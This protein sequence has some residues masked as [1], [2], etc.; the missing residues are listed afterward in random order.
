[1]ERIRNFL[2]LIPLFFLL[3]GCVEKETVDDI[4]LING[5]GFDYAE[6]G[7][8]IGTILFP[9]FMKDQP[10]ENKILTAEAAIKKSV[11]Q[12]IQK[13]SADPIVTGKMRVVLFGEELSTKQGILELVDAFQ[14]DPGVGSGIY[15]ATVDG[16]AEEILKGKYGIKGN[17][18]HIANLLDQNVKRED[19]PKTNLQRFLADFYQKGKTPYIPQIK[20]ISD[21]N[22]ELSGVGLFK[23]GKIIDTI[24]QDKMF[25]FKLLVDKF[26]EGMHRVGIEKG[27]AAIRS[28]RSSHNFELTGRNPFEVTVKIRV[29]GVINEFT[30]NELT[31]KITKQ[32]AKQFEEDIARECMYFVKRFQEKEIDPV[33]FGHFVKTQERNFNIDKWWAAEYPKLVVKIKPDVTITEAGVIQ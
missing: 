26:S 33:G 23:S 7:R 3:V 18:A 12:D 4:N 6:E 22:V 30:G 28:I 15:L 32:L 2:L 31:P 19:L 13:Q 5:I 29:E 20:K 10:P 17:A 14:R 16:T 9:V 11:L 1:M 27:D 8:I 24:T 25:F 21:E